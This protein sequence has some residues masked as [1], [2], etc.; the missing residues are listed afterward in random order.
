MEEFLERYPDEPIFWFFEPYDFNASD[1]ERVL[2]QLTHCGWFS[3][4][5]GLLIGHPLHFDGSFFGLGQYA[6]VLHRLEK[7][8]VPII[9][10]ADFGYLP[11]TLPLVSSTLAT[12][13]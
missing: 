5:G 4:A 3:R 9:T 10:G 2:R 13:T 12:V 7:R 1:M 6:A 8:R 11:P